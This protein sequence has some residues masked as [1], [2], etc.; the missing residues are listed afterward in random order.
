MGAMIQET[1][2]YTCS[3]CNSPN[4]VRNGHNKCGS[5]QSYCKDCGARRV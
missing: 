5:L 3:R 2:T 1:I 4:M